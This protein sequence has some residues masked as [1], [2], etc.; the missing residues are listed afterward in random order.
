MEGGYSVSNINAQK[1]HAWHGGCRRRMRRTTPHA[2]LRSACQAFALNRGFVY[3]DRARHR[4]TAS[5]RVP[6]PRLPL[7]LSI[8]ERDL[9][10]GLVDSERFANAGCGF[11]ALLDGGC[12]HGSIRTTCI[13]SWPPRAKPASAGLSEFIRPTPSPAPTKCG[14]KILPN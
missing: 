5:R 9:L 14:P 8:A 12:Y 6:R 2:G 1:N 13:G 7:A 11:A 4:L 10:L 3:R